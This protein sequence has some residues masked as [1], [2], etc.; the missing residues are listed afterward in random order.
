MDDQIHSTHQH[1][2][3]VWNELTLSDQNLSS[4][5]LALGTKSQMTSALCPEDPALP[6]PPPFSLAALNSVGN[7]PVLC[8]VLDIVC[9]TR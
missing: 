2:N 7:P 5:I 9:L 3:L 1:N 4:W 8:V 6:S